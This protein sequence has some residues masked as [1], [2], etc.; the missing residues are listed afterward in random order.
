MGT[1][2]TQYADGRLLVNEEKAVEERYGKTAMGVPFRIGNIKT[3]ERVLS[4]DAYLSGYPNSASGAI[5][6]PLN[7]VKTSGDT[8]LVVLRRADTQWLGYSGTMGNQVLSGTAPLYFALGG[9]ASI[10]SGLPLMGELLS[11]LG[12]I[13]GIIRIVANVIGH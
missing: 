5:C 10:T 2:I 4:I 3:V 13:S 1:I 12:A 9:L 8:L 6:A 7:E 11:G